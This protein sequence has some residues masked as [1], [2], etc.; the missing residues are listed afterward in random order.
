MPA[1]PAPL[2]A[3]LKLLGDSTRLRILALLEREELSVGELA[4][5][6]EMSQSRVSNHLKL[7]RE[8]GL[9]AERHAGASTHLR[10]AGGGGNGA[11]GTALEL[12]RSLSSQL[13]SLPEHGADLAR[14]EALVEERERKSSDFFERVA[15]DWDKL[16]GDFATG[17]ARQRA[18][19]SLLPPGMVVADL[20]CGTGYLARALLGLCARIICVDRSRAM[21]EQARARLERHA[22]GT[23]VELRAG[24]LDALPLADGEV[25][26]VLAGMVLHHVRDLDRALA[27]M[28]RALR[29]GGAAVVLEL[30]P[31][32]EAWMHEAQGDRHLGLDPRDLVAALARNGFEEPALEALDDRYQPLDPSA[33]PGE[34]R[35]ARLSLYLLRA[36]RPREPEPRPRPGST[37][38]PLHR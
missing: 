19:A 37:E 1:A 36:R 23:Q 17:Q 9:L 25:D 6:L 5:V 28:R 8:V 13:A 20:G 7:L 31:H 4:R 16:G 12:W 27:E 33:P 21:L 35:R 34:E 15:P 2:P 29:P 10:M 30:S 22:R 18:V 3:L 11:G 14:L 32:R 38:E 26:A 24:E